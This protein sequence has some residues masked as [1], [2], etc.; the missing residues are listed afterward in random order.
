M[1]FATA[2]LIGALAASTLVAAAEAQQSTQYVR[3]E[4]DGQ[5]SWGILDGSIEDGTIRQISD[6]PYLGGTATGATVQRTAVKLLAP[7]DPESVY[8]TALNFRSH[9][10]GEPAE[11]PGLFIVPP[12]S[13]IGP[14]DQIVRPADSNNLHYEAEM[15]VVV[16]R[17]AVNVSPEEAPDYVFAVTAGNDVSERGWQF[18]DLQWTRAKGSRTFNAVGPVLVT[19][20]DYENLDIAGRMNDETEIRQGENTSDMV[21]GINYMLSYISRYFTLKPG[22]LIWTGTMGTTQPMEPGD[23]Y[24][25]EVEGVGVLSNEVVQGR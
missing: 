15:V 1:R 16:G 2:A 6:A 9:I 13:I 14:E 21:F 24:H 19:G 11:Y 7:V 4:Q 12:G 10:Q 18:A 8:M 3:Y 5:A 17:E 23:V 20:L 22:D 25:V